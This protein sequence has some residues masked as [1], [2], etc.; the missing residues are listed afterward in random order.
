MS[1][2]SALIIFAKAPGID[3]KTRLRGLLSDDERVAL[4]EGLLRDTVAKLTSVDEADLYI[5]YSPAGARDYFRQFRSNMCPQVDGELGKR[6]HAAFDRIFKYGYGKAVLVG[7]DIPD[8]TASIIRDA[9]DRLDN[10]D[11]V[12]GPAKDGGYYLVG[13]K[14]CAP[15]LFEG[16]KWSCSSTLCATLK[17]A[18]SLGM[19]ITLTAELSDI[20]TADD[21]I[22]SG[23]L[24]RERH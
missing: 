9:L 24:S 10:H 2:E 11:A 6:M 8:L 21:A 7:V 16:I 23:L 15:D 1:A 19:S 13:L 14:L 17:K 12:F 5:F 4:Y 22:R 18:Q 20:D 3:A